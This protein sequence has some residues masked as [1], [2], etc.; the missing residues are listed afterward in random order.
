MKAEKRKPS[1]SRAKRQHGYR[2][3]AFMTGYL[4]INHLSDSLSRPAG[5]LHVPLRNGGTNCPADQRKKTRKS[6]G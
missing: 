4:M 5:L 3:G 2:S 6:L 1:V